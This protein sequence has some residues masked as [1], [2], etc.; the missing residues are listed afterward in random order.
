MFRKFNNIIWIVIIIG[1]V[2]LVFDPRASNNLFFSLYTISLEFYLLGISAFFVFK[3]VLFY[4]QQGET[5]TI[6]LIRNSEYQTNLIGQGVILS[7][8][9]LAYLHFYQDL[10]S[11][12]SILIG[13]LLLYYLSQVFQNAVPTIYIDERSFSYDDYFVED[14]EWKEVEEIEI[15]NGILKLIDE[16]KEFEL[17]FDLIDEIDYQVISQEM[18]RGILDGE[19][20]KNKSS[21]GLLEL[22]QSYAV[23][24]GVKMTQI[25]KARAK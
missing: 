17:N 4:R 9:Y 3:R 23:K 15:E 10:L 18:E 13:I 6:R 24:N 2:A 25:K 21:K 14:W 20:A 22:V 12:D 7:L 19:F 8:L 11:F 1:V 5:S 16:D